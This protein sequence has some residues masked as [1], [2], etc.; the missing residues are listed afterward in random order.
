MCKDFDGTSPIWVALRTWPWVLSALNLD[1]TNSFDTVCGRLV[2]DVLGD[3]VSR[4]YGCVINVD[5]DFETVVYELRSYFGFFK[6]ARACETIL[7]FYS[8]DVVTNY[9]KYRTGG[10]EVYWPEFMIFFLVTLHLW[11]HIFW[12]FQNLW[13][14]VLAYADDGN[15][16]GPLSGQNVSPIGVLDRLNLWHFFRVRPRPSRYWS[17]FHSWHVHGWGKVWGG[18]GGHRGGGY[19]STW[20]TGRIS[21]FLWSW[22]SLPVWI[23]PGGSVCN[24]SRPFPEKKKNWV[25]VQLDSA[26]C[27]MPDRSATGRG[28]L[29]N[30]RCKNAGAFGIRTVVRNP[31]YKKSHVMRASTCERIS[32]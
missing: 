14:K 1:I 32:A 15:I 21:E 5:E 8:Y 16:M 10:H 27:P 26:H 25:D 6:L 3:K 22:H 13:L 4:N 20:I 18:I 23:P 29:S 2:L 11:G 19:R 9:V 28:S 7:R 31:K 30:A 12:K 17:R 24:K